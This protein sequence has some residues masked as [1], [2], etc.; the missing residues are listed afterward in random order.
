MVQ[1]TL[2]CPGWQVKVP[3]TTDEGMCPEDAGNPKT[4][5]LLSMFFRCFA[6]SALLVRNISSLAYA[7]DCLA[8]LLANAL[9]LV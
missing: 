9:A 5:L 3:A 2:T 7:V 4:L 1:V 6:T 8:H